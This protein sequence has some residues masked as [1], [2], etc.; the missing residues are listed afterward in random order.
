MTYPVLCLAGPTAS[1]KSASSLALAQRWPIEII[2]VD[3]ATIY[4][5]MDIGT[6][7]P[8]RQEQE[9]VRHHLLDIRDP[10]ETYS[11]AAF[12]TDALQRIKETRARNHIPVLCGGTMLYYKAL[13][14]GL[15]DL[16]EADPTIRTQIDAEASLLGWPAMH[17]QLAEIDPDTAQR[18]KPNDSQRV[19]RAIEI[20][21]ASG[22]TMSSW[23]AQPSRSPATDLNFVTLSLEPSDRSALH[24]RIA[25][26]YY[27]MIEQG[28]IPEVQTFY[29]RGDLHTSLPS[30]RC[31]GY[32]QIWEYLDGAASLFAA[33]GNT[34]YNSRCRIDRQFSARKVIKKKQRLC[35]LNENVVYT[36][37]DQIDTH[38]IMTLPVKRQAQLGAYAVGTR[39]QHRLFQVRGHLEQRPKP[40]NTG[41]NTGTHGFG[42]QG[43]NAVDQGFASIDIDTRVTVGHRGSVFVC[44]EKSREVCKN[45]RLIERDDFTMNRRL[46]LEQQNNAI[47]SRKI[48]G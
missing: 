18:L 28:L 32:R 2:N 31:V 9:Q 1:G 39:H 11:A 29:D 24:E 12:R 42:R 35:T 3:S 48:L 43:F 46:R 17:A 23:L 41:H 40:A 20:Y 19:Q 47:N 13:R 34:S 7:K 21:R 30:M 16:P 14:E 38:R 45:C 4:R 27:V 6:A 10:A 44:H 15:N 8:S 5:G 33:M 36:H 25:Q 22:R 26:R 37:R